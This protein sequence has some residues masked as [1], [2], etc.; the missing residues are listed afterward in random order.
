MNNSLKRSFDDVGFD[1]TPMKKQSNAIPHELSID[2]NNILEGSLFFEEESKL[3]TISLKP[4]NN[5]K[6]K[7]VN[8]KKEKK[9]K[10]KNN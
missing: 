6:R 8:P 1:S 5:K 3:E 4:V 7:I 10:K 9:K 2:A